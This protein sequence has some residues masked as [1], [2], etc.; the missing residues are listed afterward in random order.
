LWYFSVV[1]IVVDVLGI[2]V[3]DAVFMASE[4]VD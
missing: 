1:V 2:V 3:D 4:V